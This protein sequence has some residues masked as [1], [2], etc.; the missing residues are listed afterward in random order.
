MEVEC[1]H[2]L[3][4]ETVPRADS[5]EETQSADIAGDQ[6][7]LS[8]VDRLPCRF[9]QKRVG[10]P[11]QRRALFEDH[12]GNSPGGKFD[13]GGKAAEPAANDDHGVHSA[14]GLG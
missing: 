2:R 14:C 11:S 4:G 10:A 5:F 13:A 6:H 3:Y 9:V 7:M 8:V 1:R 12:D